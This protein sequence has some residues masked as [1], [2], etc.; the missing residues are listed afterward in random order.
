MSVFY[1]PLTEGVDR[2][3]IARVLRQERDVGE[4]DFGG[5]S[6]TDTP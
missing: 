1:Y 6:T 2:V 3:L 4:G 5:G